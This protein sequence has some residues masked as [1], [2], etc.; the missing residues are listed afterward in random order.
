M[1]HDETIKLLKSGKLSR[2][3]MMKLLAAAGVGVAA[4]P[5]LSRQVTAANSRST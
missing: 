1:K 4:G 3:Q 2:R 5:M